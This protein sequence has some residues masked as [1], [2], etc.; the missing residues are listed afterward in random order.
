MPRQNFLSKDF[1]VEVEET[2]A[3]RCLL[4]LPQCSPHIQFIQE[5][6]VNKAICFLYQPSDSKKHFQVSISLLPLD[7]TYTQVALHLSYTNGQAI[8]TD[9]GAKTVLLL[10]EQAIHAALRGDINSAA[11]SSLRETSGKWKGL[12]QLFSFPTSSWFFGRRKD[13]ANI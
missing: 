11:L 10:F 6:A 4:T 1:F 8:S 12:G 13:M 3:R 9:A 7:N 2:E 5:N